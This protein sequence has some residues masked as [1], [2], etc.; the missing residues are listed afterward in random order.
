MNNSPISAN[1]SVGDITS[2]SSDHADFGFATESSKG[3][4]IVPSG[5]TRNVVL[6]FTPTEAKDYL[7]FVDMKAADECPAVTVTLVGTGVSSVLSC[8]PSPLDFGYLTPGLTAQKTLKLTN[9]GFAPVMV[10]GA[11]T[12]VGTATSTEYKLLGPDTFTVPGATR[13]NNG[14]LVPGESDVQITFTPALLGARNGQLVGGTSLSKQPMLGCPLKGVGGGPDIDVRP[15]T[16]NFGQIPFFGLSQ[17]FFSTRKITIQNLGTAPTPPDSKANL[18]L[19]VGGMGGTGGVMYW[20]VDTMDPLNSPLS[21]ICVGDYDQISGTCSNAPPSTFDN[22]TGLVA[23]GAAALLDI[24]VR[25]QPHDKGLMMQYVIHVYSDDPDEPTVDVVVKAQSVQ[26]PP[27]HATVTPTNL[28]FGLV[29][30]PQYRDLSF[31]ITNIG[32]NPGDTCLITNLDMKANSDPIFSLPGGP[33]DQVMM[34]PGDTIN[35]SV[36]AWPQGSSST[37]VMP[38]SGVVEFGIS[39]PM[40]PVRD[41]TLAA[42]IATG[43]LVISPND[44]DF[45]TVQQGCNSAKHTFNI[46]N[47]CT[48]AV[49]VQSYSMQAAAGEP[50]G[51]PNCPG[52]AACPEFLIDGTPSFSMGTQI[53]AGNT[54]PATFVLKYHPIDL[55]ADTGA[56]LLKVSQNGQTVDYIITLHGNGDTMGL[57]VDTFRQDSKPKA[58]ILLVVDNSCSMTDKQNALATNFASFIQYATQANVDFHIGLVDTDFSCGPDIGRL[59]GQGVGMGSG[60]NTTD[61]GPKVITPQTANLTTVFANRVAVGTGACGNEGA[62]EPATKALTAPLVTT[63]NAGFLRND[64]VLAIVVVSD[65]GDQSPQPATF[66]ENQ[67]RNI[68]GAQHANQFSYNDIGPFL[69]LGSSG[70]TT[71]NG[72]QCCYDDFADPSKNEYL[73]TA[74]NGVKEEICTAN[75]ATS[76]QSLG[77]TAFGYRTN[78]FLNATPDLTGGK[79]ITVA[80]DY[81]DGNGPQPLGQTDMGRPVWSYD[82]GSNAIIFTTFYVPEPGDTLTVTYY[83][84]CN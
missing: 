10:M 70:C 23:A 44:L 32:T 9:Q 67:L 21:D 74:F 35:V 27:C 68:K 16:L 81:G 2:N 26:L 65:A 71:V 52:M 28:N 38:A 8:D 29:T 49:T 30:P 62:V 4:F 63:D 53:A 41:V 50:A 1:A 43:C 51:G 72:Q 45:G 3:M 25:I 33:L 75:W 22:M 18:H 55:G 56:F 13:D 82:S 64:A 69:G 42:S 60:G 66:Y 59:H 11:K 83:V 46:Y 54:T 36:R 24:P 40:T 14:D 19:G 61:I 31:T 77:K 84:A 80:I 58:D 76:L 12:Q 37:Q 78:F 47:T 20:T 73:I 57:N 34:M 17:P 39:D 15:T 6:T 7:A 48:Q 5:G 79:M